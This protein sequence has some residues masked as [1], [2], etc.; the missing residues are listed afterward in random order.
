M[1]YHAEMGPS[2][3]EFNPQEDVIE[4]VKTTH[5]GA[6]IQPEVSYGV[7]LMSLE[8]FLKETGI[9]EQVESGG[10]VKIQALHRLLARLDVI[11]DDLSSSRNIQEERMKKSLTGYILEHYSPTELE[12]IANKL[13]DIITDPSRT[14]EDDERNILVEQLANIQK[15]VTEHPEE[16]ATEQRRAA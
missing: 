3:L 6:F 5:D 11:N 14:L 1:K 15:F 16:S 9:G 2:D 8:H 4:T 7:K 13:E 12:S 10:E